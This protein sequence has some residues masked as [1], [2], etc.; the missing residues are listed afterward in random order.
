MHLEM[1]LKDLTANQTKI[2]II[3]HSTEYASVGRYVRDI[4]EQQEGICKVINIIFNQNN[5]GLYPNGLNVNGVPSLGVN[6][7]FRMTIFREIIGLLESF[8]LSG[9][10][11]HYA[12]SSMPRI[13]RSSVN[14]IVTFH[15]VFPLEEDKRFMDFRQRLYRKYTQSFL[16]YDSA[17]AISNTTKESVLGAGFSG[18]I[19]VIYNMFDPAFKP[20]NDKSLIRAKYSIPEGKSIVLSVST[21]ERRKNLPLVYHSM[22]SAGEDFS[23]IRIGPSIGLGQSF[24][25]VDRQTLVELYQASDA[26]LLTSTREGFNYPV[27]EAMASGMPVVVSDIPIM[28]EIVG[29]AGI[30]CDLNDPASFVEGLHKATEYASYYSAKSLERAKR[31]SHNVF[32]EKMQKFYAKL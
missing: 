15:D 20:V 23:L 28:R 5:A 24:N 16:K 19:E 13:T 30:L 18:E 4:K 1:T 31:Y 14:E 9:G 21:D 2:L 17:I 25:K 32:K 11:V 7:L 10:F 8:K 22:R 27:V 26:F 29:N 12:E 6:V 3:N